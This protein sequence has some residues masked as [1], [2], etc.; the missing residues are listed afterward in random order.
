MLV[1]TALDPATAERISAFATSYRG[2]ILPLVFAVGLLKSTPVVAMFIPSTA[3]FVVMA[4]AFSAGG[5][6]FAPLWLAAAIGATTGDAVFYG[7]GAHHRHGI[8]RLWPISKSPE[9]LAR[10]EALFKR[11]GILSV[12]GAKFVWGVR[13]FIPVIA[14]MYRMPFGLFLAVTNLSSLVWAGIGMGAGF[15]LWQLLN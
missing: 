3:M 9:L 13:P 7:L 15:G 5:G 1:I 14:G 4:A 12:L 8:A 11:W 2:W 10:G 6:T